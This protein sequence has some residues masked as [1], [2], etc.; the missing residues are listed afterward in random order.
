MTR[1]WLFLVL[2]L[3]LAACPQPNSSDDDDAV[4]DDD[5][6][7]GDDDDSGVGD[8]DDTTPPPDGDGDGVP[9]EDDPCPEDPLNWSDVDG[10]GHCDQTDD[11]CA[12]D[13]AQWTDA[14]G[15]GICDEVEDDCP[16]D[17]NG[18]NDTNADG[19][20]DDNDDNDGD[21][22]SNGEEA[23]WGVDCAISDPDDPDTDGDGYG[24]NEDLYPL[25][26]YPEYILWRN[27][28]GTMDLVLS[29]RDGTF[30]PPADIGLP[31]GDTTNTDYRY[32][33]FSISDYDANGSTDFLAYGDADPSDPSNPLDLWW[34]G[35]VAGPTSF[36]QRLV[37]GNVAGFISG[38]ADLDNDN[39]LDVFHLVRNSGGYI[40]SLVLYTYLNEGTVATANCAWTEDPTNPDGCVFIKQQAIDLTTWGSGKWIARVGRD[41]VDVDGDGN[42]DLVMVTHSS[43]G[44]S[45]SPVTLLLGDGA[46]GFTLTSHELFTHGA[47][48]VNSQIFAD[49]NGDDLGDLIVGL[50][51]DGDAGSAWFY[52][53]AWDAVNG[54]SISTGAAFESFDLNP[55][56]ESGGENYGVTTTARS[57]DFDFD[58]NEDILLGYNTTEPWNPPSQ[59][60][61]LQGNGNGT[62]AAPTIVRSFTNAYGQSFTIP[63]RLCKRFQITQ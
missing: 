62:F 15:D 53:G 50:D 40:S 16:G 1:S 51:D 32:I 17:P 8:D 33:G 38:A 47:S 25:D 42:R 29:N 31:Y 55:G 58:G 60:V 20:C 21:G 36:V 9:D 6:S 4:T 52:P 26:P 2:L 11:A 12:G 19:L 39:D 61:F 43:G 49:F 34:F 35:R 30:Q 37:D 56:A 14:D 59:T 7:A 46:G 5:D 41:A 3:G 10:D 44:A 22:I 45:S 23:D 13:D 27:D 28:T 48:P 57:F 18:W 24:D 54:Y 63:Q